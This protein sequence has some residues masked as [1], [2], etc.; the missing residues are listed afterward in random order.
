MTDKKKSRVEIEQ[1]RQR[2][3]ATEET[4]MAMKLFLFDYFHRLGPD[5]KQNIDVIVETTCKALNS[6]VALYNRL[7]DGVLKTWS[8]YNEPPD[9][10][11]EDSP[12]GHICYDMTI[13]KRSADNFSPVIL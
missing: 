3:I 10:K 13:R 8:I 1:E 6:D 12:S 9:F 11:R 4:L 7:E 5:P 2:R